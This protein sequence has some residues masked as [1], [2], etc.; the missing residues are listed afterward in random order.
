MDQLKSA[1]A[2]RK[3]AKAAAPA[4]T[5]DIDTF[6]RVKKLKRPSDHFPASCVEILKVQGNRIVS[7]EEVTKPDVI[8]MT[9]S[10]AEEILEDGEFR[11]EA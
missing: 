11:P 3:A 8:E 5:Q 9:I 10:R 4:S 2:Q 1:L 7:R 6:V